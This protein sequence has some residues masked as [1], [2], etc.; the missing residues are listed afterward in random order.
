MG[1]YV[2]A[3]ARERSEMPDWFDFM[4]SFSGEDK[5]D[6]ADAL[7]EIEESEELLANAGIPV[8][9][10]KQLMIHWLRLQACVPDERGREGEQAFVDAIQELGIEM[11]T[12]IPLALKIAIEKD[13]DRE[14]EAAEFGSS[15]ASGFMFGYLE[16]LEKISKDAEIESPYDVIERKTKSKKR[17]RRS[18]T[19]ISMAGPADMSSAEELG[20]F[21]R[22]QAR[23]TSTQ[24]DDPDD[25]W[26]PVMLVVSRGRAALVGVEI[27]EDENLKR[28]LLGSLLPTTV[29]TQFGGDKPIAVGLVVSSWMLEDDSPEHHEWL[30]GLHYGSHD[31]AIRHHPDRVEKLVCYLADGS[32]DQLWMATIY[33]DGEQP[34]GLG[35]WERQLADKGKL[36]GL[37]PGMLHR[38]I[39]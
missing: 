14:E 8:E 18:K 12:L 2:G 30:E 27:P 33:R 9:K 5:P 31:E 17:K 21:L 13:F 16:A 4:E 25:D 1:E 3:A 37:I 38:I 10:L 36:G 23:D 28:K 34:P 11:M 29:R 32:G 15:F 6:I 19:A 7:N 26:M 22:N 20:E 35:E 39:R 24:F